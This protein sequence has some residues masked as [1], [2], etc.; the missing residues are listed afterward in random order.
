LTGAD[1]SGT[2]L[3]NTNLRDANL[4]GADLSRSN[5][6]TADFTG[7]TMPDGTKYP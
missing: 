5:R 6:T 4:V 3:L 2:F 1:L 7:A